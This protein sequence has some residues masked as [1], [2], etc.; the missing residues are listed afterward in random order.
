MQGDKYPPCPHYKKKNHTSKYCW[1][2]PN[3]KCRSYNQLGYV[4]KVCKAKGANT[5]EKTTVVE[6]ANAKDELLFM[7]TVRA[8]SKLKNIWLINS[9]C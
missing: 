8:E 9:G 2:W 7:A 6:Q 3:V 4:E 1:Y 5:E